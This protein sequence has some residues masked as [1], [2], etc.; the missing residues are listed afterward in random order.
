MNTRDLY[1]FI[2]MISKLENLTA[3]QNNLLQS[4]KKQV[5]ERNKES[6]TRRI[7]KDNGIDGYIEL[8]PLP[9][10]ISEKEDAIKF[11]E[12]NRRIELA[13]SAYDCTGRPFTGWYKVFKRNGK[14]YAYHSVCFDV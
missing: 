9:A 4:L 8:E 14:F 3:E 12:E 13:P 7:V 10:E 5:R 2:S 6:N 1:F 11:F